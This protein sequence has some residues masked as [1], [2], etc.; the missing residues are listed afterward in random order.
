MMLTG[1]KKGTVGL[2]S[3]I[4]GQTL[5]LIQLASSLTKMRTG[6]KE[7]ERKIVC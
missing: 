6:S 5:M 1:I 7:K 4:K 2:G 3:L